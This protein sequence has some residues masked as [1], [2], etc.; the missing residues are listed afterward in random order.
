MTW[1]KKA[2]IPVRITISRNPEM[3]EFTERTRKLS[4]ACSR[5]ILLSLIYVVLTSVLVSSFDS[6]PT[7]SSLTSSVARSFVRNSPCEQPNSRLPHI[8]ELL[9]SLFIS[10]LG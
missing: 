5:S 4:L 6:P 3:S 1:D 10:Y 7:T 9:A 8:F 2:Q